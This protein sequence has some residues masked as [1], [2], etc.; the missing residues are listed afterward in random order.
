M[1]VVAEL[2][3]VAMVIGMWGGGVME[4]CLKRLR[5]WLGELVCEGRLLL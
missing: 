3:L 4:N 5:C 2:V 1:L